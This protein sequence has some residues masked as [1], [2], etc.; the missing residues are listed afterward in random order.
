MPWRIGTEISVFRRWY[1]TRFF[2]G[3]IYIFEMVDLRA[4]HY[5]V[6]IIMYNT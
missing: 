2:C 1:T 4:G 6:G 3:M 5:Y